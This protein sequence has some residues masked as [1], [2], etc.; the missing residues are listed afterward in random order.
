LQLLRKAVES[1]HGISQ[2][3]DLSQ[4]ELGELIASGSPE[5]LSRLVETGTVASGARKYLTRLIHYTAA[6]KANDL[7]ATLDEAAVNLTRMDLI[8]NVVFPLWV[9]ID[10]LFRTGKLKRIHLNATTM[11]LQTFL[12]N[13][14]RTAVV[15]RSAP[16][17]IIATPT[18]QHC[19]IE[20]LALAIV[21][22][23]CGWKSI[24]F[25]PN[26]S[27]TD[28]VAAVES[29]QTRAVALSIHQLNEKS[30]VGTEIKNLRKNLNRAIAVII[31]GNDG[32]SL[33]Q[34]AELDGVFLT[35][36]NNFRQKLEDISLSSIN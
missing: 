18:G 13:M 26:L 2:V 14:L 25:G 19:E 24:Y 30:C 7:Q 31:C 33:N 21:A 36:F 5:S 34:L 22:V 16:R 35:R 23:E 9:R 15:S 3:A 4:A 32:M 11:S 6:I 20:A 1:G 29:N 12:W 10:E 28:T 8:L 17:I 27:A